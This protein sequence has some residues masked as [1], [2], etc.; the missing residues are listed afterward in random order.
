MYRVVVS[1]DVA[2]EV[3]VEFIFFSRRPCSPNIAEFRALLKF[4]VARRSS[5]MASVNRKQSG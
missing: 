2:K 3:G 4:D 1:R 5:G